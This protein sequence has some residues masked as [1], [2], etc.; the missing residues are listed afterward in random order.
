[1]MV[2]HLPSKTERQFIDTIR[3]RPCHA[4]RWKIED[5]YVHF[6]EDEKVSES[7]S[8]LLPIIAKLGP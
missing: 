7:F 6:E 4:S 2:S 1:M 5:M 3:Y 8:K